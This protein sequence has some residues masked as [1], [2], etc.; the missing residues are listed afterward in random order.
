[1]PLPPHPNT[2]AS[3]TT[4]LFPTPEQ[5]VRHLSEVGASRGQG[6]PEHRHAV[7]LACLCVKSAPDLPTRST[8]ILAQLE[9]WALG[10]NTI[11]LTAIK[12]QADAIA[13]A[14][15]AAA[16]AAE[17]AVNSVHEANKATEEAKIAD[18]CHIGAVPVVARY[19]ADRSGSV[20]AAECA[21][22]A[23]T[24]EADYAA[25]AKDAAAKAEGATAKATEASS[26]ARTTAA[27]YAAHD[28]NGASKAAAAAAHAVYAVACAAEDAT[29][30][31]Q[32]APT[33]HAPAPVAVVAVAATAKA[34]GYAAYAA[35]KA[36]KATNLV[37]NAAGTSARGAYRRGLADLIRAAVPVCP[38]CSPVGPPCPW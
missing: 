24:L 14:A 25:A 22:Y 36:A 20:E 15:E 13:N 7:L 34:V 30:K 5:L 27:G 35:A 17:A 32:Y 16:N 19:A 4:P 31:D 9:D 10:N 38:S 12:T 8:A 23:A 18:A 21:D 3:S 11:H 33:G 28:P 26:V 37:A 29:A 1:M 2:T 6:S